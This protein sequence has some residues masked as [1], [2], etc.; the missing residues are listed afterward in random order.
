M[1][2]GRGKALWLAL[3]LA[4][5]AVF[6]PASA[7]A[8]QSGDAVTSSYASALLNENRRER[9][10]LIGVD[11][12]VTK[13]SA[14][15][16]STNNVYA[17]Q[18]TF[19]NAL[20][21]LDALLIPDEP[22]TSAQALTRLIQDTF[23]DAGEGD[24]SYLYISTHGVFDPA[25]GDEPVLLLSDGVT[26]GRVTAAELEA[27]FD[28]I[29][30]KKVILLDACN[31][32]A[33]IGKGQA[34]QPDGL[35]FLG[36][37]FKVLTSSG[38]L[39]ESWYWK[40]PE[41]MALEEGPQGTA[42][43]DI[44]PQ[45]AF[46]FTQAL[47]QAL[48]PRYNYPADI[49]QDGN[50]TL[51][52]LYDYLLQNHAASTP[53]V[54]PQQDDFIVFRYDPEAPLPQGLDRSPILDVTFSGTMLD[55]S[56]QRVTLEYIATR[57]VRVAYQI[58]Y[59]QGGK[60]LFDEAQLLFDDV[61]RFTAFGDQRGAVSAG[62]KVRTFS[63]NLEEGDAYGYVLVQVLSIDRGKVTVHA[64]RVLCIPPASGDLGLA[65]DVKNQYIR[66]NLREL[67]I[68]VEHAYPCA[69]SVAIVDERDQVVRRLCHRRSTRPAQ[70]D[71]SGSLFYW[72]GTDKN[73]D[74][75]PPGTYHVRVSGIMNDLPLTIL[76]DPILIV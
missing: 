2:G 66:S 26:E 48:S 43:E 52:E 61:E 19:Q 8:Q 10:L 14:Y 73:G 23:H 46:Y 53:Q 63:V 3:W 58:V 71:P 18:E 20:H 39:E 41:G 21:P 50:I 27:A 40:N 59:Q 54:Y 47:S 33:F 72:D 38:A 62:R 34:T 5:F 76:S 45:G 13:P 75:V 67:S 11:D 6:S 60:W 15:P 17:M 1:Q 57:P 24:V 36:E 37:D 42:P 28:G 74:P 68:F 4:V 31:S 56:S 69:L 32:G 35:H 49:N 51:S 7:L 29:P 55:A 70:T 30:G 64:G 22:V 25:S 12:F 44:Q 9:A 16:S 65:V